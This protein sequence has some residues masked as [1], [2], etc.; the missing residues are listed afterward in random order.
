MQVLDAGLSAAL[1]RLDGCAIANAIETFDVRLR[2][3]GFTDGRIRCLFE[4]QPPVVGHA[5]T[6]RIRA[7]TPP[8][9]GHSYVDRTDWWTYISTVQAPR[10][11]VVQDVDDTAGRGA[12]VGEVHANILRALD[13][14]AY[15]TNGAVR[16]LEGVGRTGLQLFAGSISVSHAYVHIVDFGGPVEVAGLSVQSGDLL[17]GDCHGLQSIPPAIAAKIPA[18]AAEMQAREQR[19]IDFCKSAEFSTEGLRAIV[20]GSRIYRT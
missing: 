17:F 20:N 19:V 4:R 8:A 5:V 16:D 18:V 12:L 6:A 2:N 15:A 3:E 14:E 7:S 9:V 10:I 1:R 13:C 11:V